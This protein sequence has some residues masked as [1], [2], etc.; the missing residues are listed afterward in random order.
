MVKEIDLDD[1]EDLI[2]VYARYQK[3][4]STHSEV[5]VKDFARSMERHSGISVWRLS[6]RTRTD[7]INALQVP[8]NKVKG[9]LIAKAGLLK[10]LG[11]RFVDSPGNGHIAARCNN[12]NMETSRDKLCQPVDGKECGLYLEAKE[13]LCVTLSQN[14]FEIDDAVKA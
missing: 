9:T 3:Q 1:D 5:V 6:L 2:R 11:I 12:C 13:S 7:A 4:K 14:C 10:K 8:K